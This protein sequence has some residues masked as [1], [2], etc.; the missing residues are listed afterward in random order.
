MKISH[1]RLSRY[2]FRSVEVSENPAYD[3]KAEVANFNM[4]VGTNVARKTD[5]SREWRVDLKLKSG[6]PNNGPYHFLVELSG[7]FHIGDDYPNDRLESLIQANGPAVLFGAARE[8]I[9]FISS[10][11]QT[12]FVLPLVTF[13]D[14]IK[15]SDVN[16]S[17]GL[18]PSGAKAP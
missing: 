14:Q 6:E 18:A 17:E 5:G 15:G 1:L 2:W 13:I 11:G 16:A 7:M 10:R 3:A 8:M 12:P 4:E 9:M